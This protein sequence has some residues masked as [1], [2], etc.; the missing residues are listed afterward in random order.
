MSPNETRVLF[1]HGLESG[2]NGLKAN[3]LR[4]YY[5]H[6]SCPH[7]QTPKNLWASFATIIREVR[8]FKPDIIIGSSY[9]S[10]LLMLMLQM[11]I[12]NGPSIILACA[13]HLIAKHRMFIPDGV[14]PDRILMVH[15]IGDSLCD[16]E[17]V[18]KMA[19]AYGITLLE[20]DDTHSLKTICTDD[21]IQSE[22]KITA[23]IDKM[24]DR[25]MG[26]LPHVDLQ[27][28]VSTYIFRLTLV[29]LWALIRYPF[30]K[31]LY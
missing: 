1:I 12:W 24:V 28:N 27:T 11:G 8:L 18:Q 30:N 26:D 9:G 20:I 10:I 23:L 31:C 29:L 22:Y 4:D 7:L 15:G 14:N 13:M 5:K 2:P 16:I 6:F 3:V 17:S 25:T 21:S 19:Q